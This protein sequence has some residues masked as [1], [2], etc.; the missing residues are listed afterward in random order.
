[1]KRILS[2]QGGGI[3]GI[4]P[5]CQLVELEMQTGKLTRD[6]FD[7]VGGTSTGA[8]LAAAIAAG[9][10][11]TKSLD[12]YLKRGPEIF[13][14]ENQ[15]ERHFN[16]VSKGRQFNSKVLYNVLVGTLGPVAIGWAINDSPVGILITASN[17]LGDA[18]Y[19]TQDRPTNAGKLGKYRM[20][21]AA[22]ASACAT[23]YHDPWLVSTM[24]SDAAR[25]SMW[26]ADGGLTGTAD[27]V[28]ETCVEA[29]SG[30][31][32]YGTI[33]PKEALVVSLGTGY[34]KPPTMPNPPGPLL[35]RIAWGFSSL[36]GSSKT[37]AA[38]LVARHWP[39]VPMTILNTEMASNVD[40]ADTDKI[41]YLYQTGHAAAQAVNWVKLLGL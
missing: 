28:Y 19:F 7:F 10:P 15:F 14:P 40:E 35:Q 30:Y 32:C 31:M 38:Q 17:Q 3:R 23:T 34:Y 4:L 39:D 20:V 21:D 22:V 1:M 9:V 5:A 11:A 18:Q 36:V 24:Y 26:C 8:L 27:P 33:D 25:P 2:I 29:F 13:S 41:A 16:L 37:L 12:V 6:I